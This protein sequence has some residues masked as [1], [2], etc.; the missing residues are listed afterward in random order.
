MAK[1]TIPIAGPTDAQSIAEDLQVRSRDCLLR[2]DLAGFADCYAVPSTIDC[3]SGALPVTSHEDMVEFFEAVREYFFR[4]NVGDL[5]CRVLE[6]SFRDEDTIS[7]S[8]EARLVTNEMLCLK[9]YPVYW[10][11]RRQEGVWRVVYAQF[12]IPLP[13]RWGAAGRALAAQE[14]EALGDLHSA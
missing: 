5:S 12:A 7:T 2:G 11:I 14:R 3:L 6:A 13:M 8:H 1:E 9:P 10:V 4:S